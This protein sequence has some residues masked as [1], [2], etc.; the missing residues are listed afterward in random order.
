[1]MTAVPTD[2]SAGAGKRDEVGMVD[3]GRVRLVDFFRRGVGAQA[4]HA[5][6][7]K[8]DGLRIGG[9]RDTDENGKTKTGQE[10]AG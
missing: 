4:G 6:G 7:P 8:L 2:L 1:M 5:L 3:V 10:K 9:E